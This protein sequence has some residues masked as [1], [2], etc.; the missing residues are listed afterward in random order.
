MG[1][2]LAYRDGYYIV[3]CGWVKYLLDVLTKLT[4]ANG[5][6]GFLISYKHK[7]SL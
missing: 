6:N 5:S 7:Y 4:C 1:F 2:S 3:K